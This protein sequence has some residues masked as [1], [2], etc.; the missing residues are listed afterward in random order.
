MGTI[1]VVR[2]ANLSKWGSDVGLSKHIYKIG[3]TDGSA[4]DAAAA[5]WAGET[6]WTL[7]KKLDGVEGLNEDEIVDRVARKVKM[8][9][10]NLYPRVKGVRGI[11]KVT[12][13]A[14]ENHFLVARA[15]A[16]DQ[17]QAPKIKHPDFGAFLI[18]N[19]AP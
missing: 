7:V 13:T 9:D 1:Y 16:G 12:P 18:A 19:A 11:F 14:V 15:Y 17:L 10:P 6:D 5:G 4:K 8:I 2:S 3:Y